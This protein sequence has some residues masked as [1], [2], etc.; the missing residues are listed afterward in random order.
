MSA[1]INAL[2][3]ATAGGSW[4]LTLAEAP[5]K[6][7]FGASNEEMGFYFLPDFKLKFTT[8][9]QAE[10][11]AWLHLQEYKTMAVRCDSEVIISAGTR[12]KHR[13]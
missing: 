6:G 7:I 5:G 10:T 4:I 13:P 12:G 8:K 1:T 11:W 2:V 9:H 3:H